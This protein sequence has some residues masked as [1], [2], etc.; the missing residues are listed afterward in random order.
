MV[1]YGMVWWRRPGIE[2]WG[3][4]ILATVAL[5]NTNSMDGTNSI[6]SINS[7]NSSNSIEPLK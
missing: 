7:G 6:N 5:I 4:N 2:N 1:W 3:G